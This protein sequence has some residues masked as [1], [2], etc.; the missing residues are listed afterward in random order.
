[1]SS[2]WINAFRAK[3]ID[4][5]P[6]YFMLHV[7]SV[8][9]EEIERPIASIKSPSDAGK[10]FREWREGQRITLEEPT[11]PL[12]GFD[13]GENFAL[14]LAIERRLPILLDDRAPYNQAITRGLTV[15]SSAG[16]VVLLYTD[17]RV[18]YTE[19]LDH[20]K[21]TE[22]NKDLLRENLQTLALVAQLKGDR[23]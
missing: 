2:F 6:D 8:V 13:V 10:L 7:P 12:D 17:G 5:L 11:H 20:I 9:V 1:D 23:T 16:F 22:I 3:V 19:A 18:S 4:F 21:A 15:V 14:A